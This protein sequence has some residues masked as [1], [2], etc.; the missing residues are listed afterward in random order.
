MR[1]IGSLV[2]SANVLN[3]DTVIAPFT[4]SVHE[5][6]KVGGQPIAGVYIEMG[7]SVHPI[8]TRQKRITILFP[9]VA[10]SAPIV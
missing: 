4:L 8:L 5:F 7:F 9:P 2:F 10:V 3:N 6:L 1:K